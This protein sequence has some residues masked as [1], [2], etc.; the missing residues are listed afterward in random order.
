MKKTIV[1]MM[2]FV[3][4]GVFA[5]SNLVK[6]GD[7]ESGEMKKAKHSNAQ[8]AFWQYFVKQGNSIAIVAGQ[9]HEGKNVLCIKSNSKNEKRF[10]TC[11][12]QTIGVLKSS[13]VKVTFQALSNQDAKI[14]VFVTGSPLGDNTKVKLTST[15]GNNASIYQSTK[16]Q[17]YTVKLSEIVGSGKTPIDFSKPLEIRLALLGDYSAAPLELFI[18]NVVVTYVGK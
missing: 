14:R 16:F 8:S 12:S 18:D 4:T 2:L 6:D 11:I 15:I 5:Q 13:R 3:V 7:F 10:T 1:I 17:T 9:A